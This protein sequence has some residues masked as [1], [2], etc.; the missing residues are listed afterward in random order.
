M[1]G[2][3]A[4][5]A[6]L[7]AAV[8]PHRAARAVPVDALDPGR[9]WRLAAL[10]VQGAH[11]VPKSAVR[12]A[13]VTKARPWFAFWMVWRPLPAFEPLTFG[14]DLDRVR[15]LYR[16][17]GYYEARIDHDVDVPAEGDAVR[18]VVR[19]DEGPVVRVDDVS[20]ALRGEELPAADR[21]R[22]L[23][24]LPLARGRV[25]TQDAYERTFTVLRTYYRE[26]GFARV[27]VT[28]R[29]T[30]DV[31]Q[32][33][34][35]V[36][37]EV[38]S[39]PASVFGE[40]RVTGT[41]TVDADVVR[42]EVQF[43]PGDPFKQSLVER[44]RANLVALRLFRSIRIDEVPGPDPRVDVRIRVVEG[45]KHEVRVGVGYDTEEQI[46]GL[47]SWRDY[48]FL[49]GGRQLGF[50]AR[51]SFLR[52]TIAADFVQPHFPG[53]RDRLRLL[54]AED[55]EEEDTYTNDRTRFG[56]RIEWQALPNLVPYAFYR[57]EYDSL[58]SVKAVVRN[59]RTG[60]APHN[61]ILSGLGF[62]IDFNATDDPLDPSVGWVTLASVEPVGGFL[63]GDFSFVRATAEGRRYQP[64]VWGLLGAFRLRLGAA[65]PTG[66]TPEI[67]LFERFYAGG[68]NSVRGYDRRRIG[69]LVADDPVG[70]RTL[71]ETS[72]ELRHPITEKIGA[73]V[74]VDA[75]QVSLRSFDFP[76][77]DL[78]YG[79][80]F[81]VRYK[82]P[83]GPLRLDLGFPV[84]PPPGDARWQVHVSLGQTF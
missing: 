80:G 39:G 3:A 59:F 12:Q 33:T 78:R 5:V 83:V 84:Q 51:A 41:H 27:E 58:S 18:V 76:F 52:R 54:L 20:V 38:D 6:L 19:V 56:P 11:G 35:T 82:S 64:L 68:I 70:G 1:R 60:L 2:R 40:V 26:H 43:H 55:Q 10:D 16:N 36:A 34:A 50:T 29:A 53:L 45:P 22:L 8:V 17:H 32:R 73:A 66:G 75:G 67:P 30:V 25:F 79:S 61:G 44:T 23:T 7:L 69:P 74:F 71:V 62:G 57:I 21:E 37:Y 42:R 4:L 31:P 48:D 63:G 15:Q 28:R 13:M 77:G 14:T 46:R 72:A 24:H 81:G 65:D 49:G 9:E 47:A